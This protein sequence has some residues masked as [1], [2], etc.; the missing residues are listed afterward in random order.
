MVL[1]RLEFAD[2]S[3]SELCFRTLSNTKYVWVSSLPAIR[4]YEIRSTSPEY[5]NV[6]FE[7]IL[8]R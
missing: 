4:S 7:E 8:S 3:S 5:S 6:I 2:L 1:F